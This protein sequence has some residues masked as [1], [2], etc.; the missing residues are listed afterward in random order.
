MSNKRLY[1]ARRRPCFLKGVALSYKAGRHRC[2]ALVL[3]V[4]TLKYFYVEGF[5]RQ[6]VGHVS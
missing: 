6:G 2:G 5:N 1:K 4:V 3:C